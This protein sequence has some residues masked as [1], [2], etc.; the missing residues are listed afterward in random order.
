MAHSY[1]LSKAFDCMNHNLLLLKPSQ[2]NVS[3]SAVAHMKSYLNNRKQAVK[4]KTYVSDIL[5]IIIVPQGL[6]L[7]PLLYIFFTK[8]L[9]NNIPLHIKLVAHADARSTG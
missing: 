3:T 1:D 4:C 9:I 6:V 7:G 8:N 2:Y 5:T